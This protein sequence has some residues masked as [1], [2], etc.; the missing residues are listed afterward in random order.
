MYMYIY[1]YIYIYIHIYSAPVLAMAVEGRAPSPTLAP[2]HFACAL[3][4][5]LSPSAPCVCVLPDA[6]VTCL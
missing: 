1:K 3:S 6:T 4:Q 5:E 2:L